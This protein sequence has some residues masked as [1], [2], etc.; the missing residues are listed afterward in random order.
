MGLRVNLEGNWSPSEATFRVGLN[1]K[2]IIILAVLVAICSAEPGWHRRP[3]YTHHAPPA[4]PPPPKKPTCACKTTYKTIQKVGETKKE[5][6]E[7]KNVP[8]QV[9]H[10]V[11]EKVCTGV[12]HGHHGR[13]KRHSYSRKSHSYR[14]VTHSYRAPKTHS[15]R[16]SYAPV[17]KPKVYH[18]PAPKCHYKKVQKCSTQHEKVCHKTYVTV[19]YTYEEK[20]PEQVCQTLKKV[21]KV[22]KEKV[23]EKVGK[24]ECHKV[25]VKTCE[26]K[27]KKECQSVPE[28][29][30]HY[31]TRKVCKRDASPGGYYGHYKHHRPSCTHKKE[32]VCNVVHKQVCHDK[33]F[34]VCSTN[35]KEECK[36]VYETIYKERDVKVEEEVCAW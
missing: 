14:P 12:S 4:H 22:I 6:V 1:M 26:T 21:V 7:C 13:Y 25:P 18:K 16:K 23:P 2:T 9:C 32:Q 35:Y 27:T 11:H 31:V 17:H 28:H 19:P 36:T 5:S 24:L 33:H 10:D 15:Y 34:P 30:C 8:K 20:V 29:K 3:T